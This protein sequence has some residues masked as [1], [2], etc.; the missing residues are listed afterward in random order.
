[1]K[2]MILAAGKSTRL[3]PITDTI[4][5]PMVPV[6][7]KPLMEYLIELFAS[8]NVQEI[9]VNLHHCPQVIS[10]YFGD[11]KRWG[12]SINY[13]YEP[14]ILGTAGAVKKLESHFDKTFIVVYGD[15]LTDCNI[16]ELIKF[17]RST[18]GIGTIA[19]YRRDDPTS[20][21]IVELDENHRILRFLEKPKANQVF[22]NLISAGIFILEPE[23]LKYIPD[24]QFYDFGR[25]LFPRLLK[26]GERLYGYIMSEDLFWI[27]TPGDY[28]RVQTLFSKGEK[29]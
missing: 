5:K 24:N 18:N 8:H 21:G 1:M 29:L 16:T 11:G 7:G 20:S 2:A 12:V 13:S 17:H 9:Y 3:R 27:D 10:N 26:E 23:I 28:Q 4:P 6:N 25:D 15:N 14:E 22:S 19:I